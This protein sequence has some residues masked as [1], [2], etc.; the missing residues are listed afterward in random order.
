MIGER[1]GQM[2]ADRGKNTGIG[3]DVDGMIKKCRKGWRNR[4]QDGGRD[5]GC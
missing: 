2:E 3:R 5:D 1:D 4:E